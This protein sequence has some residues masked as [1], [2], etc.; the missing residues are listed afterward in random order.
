ML[1]TDAQRLSQVLINLLTNANKFTEKGRITLSCRTDAARGEAV[2]S[3]ADTGCGI[4]RDKREYVF[5]RF[6]KVDEFT[7]GTGIGLYLARLI[8]ER[9]QGRIWVDPDYTD[10]TRFVFTVG[11]SNVK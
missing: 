6:T 11:L 5:E 4:D 8:I 3:V 9:M 2:F 7:P 10:G 1:T